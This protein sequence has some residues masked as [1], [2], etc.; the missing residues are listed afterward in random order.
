MVLTKN[1]DV[2]YFISVDE[3]NFRFS[4]NYLSIC[5]LASLDVDKK[6]T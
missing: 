2:E 5:I 3:P 6:W 1:V 4:T